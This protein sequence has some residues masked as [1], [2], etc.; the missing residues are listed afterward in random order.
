[1]ASLIPKIIFINSKPKC[2]HVNIC[3]LP[4]HSVLEKIFLL[5]W[6]I[7]LLGI[8]KETLKD[9]GYIYAFHLQVWKP[10]LKT[11]D[12]CL[13]PAVWHALIPSTHFIPKVPQVTVYTSFSD[14]LKK[15][16]CLKD[17][18]MLLHGCLLLSQ[19]RACG[20]KATHMVPSMSTDG[21][22][23]GWTCYSTTANQITLLSWKSPGDSN[24]MLVKKKKKKMYE[25]D[26]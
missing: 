11:W 2:Q 1:M 18:R 13:L 12:V 21:L 9:R 15:P 25:Q 4:L 22:I 3:V 17:L 14:T 5:G 16:F 26:S 24:N 7:S 10:L 23:Q 8:L 6:L 20:E 19:W